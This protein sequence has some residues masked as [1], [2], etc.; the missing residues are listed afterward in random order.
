MC[1]GE[2][3]GFNCGHLEPVG[4]ILFCAKP[5]C[6]PRN[7]FG[8]KGFKNTPCRTC[9]M[10]KYTHDRLV[11]STSVPNP[12]TVLQA[13]HA[14]NHVSRGRPVIHPGREGVDMERSAVLDSV[15]QV[16][17]PEGNV[18]SG[19]PTMKAGETHL[20]PTPPA[21]PPKAV[22]QNI[23]PYTPLQRCGTQTHTA[24]EQSSGPIPQKAQL[25]APKALVSPQRR[26]TEIG[27]ARQQSLRQK[28][29]L[30]GIPCRGKRVRQASPGDLL[31]PGA[32]AHAFTTKPP[33]TDASPPRPAQLQ[34]EEAARLRSDSDLQRHSA[35]RYLEGDRPRPVPN[36]RPIR[37]TSNKHHVPNPGKTI[38]DGDNKIAGDGPD[39]ARAAGSNQNTWIA[40][41]QWKSRIA[42]EEAFSR[43]FP[44]DAVR[45]LKTVGPVFYGPSSTSAD[46]MKM[47][48]PGAQIWRPPP[49]ND[50][51]FWYDD[52]DADSRDWCSDDSDIR[53]W[54]WDDSYSRYGSED[55][56]DAR[57]GAP[58]K[59]DG[60][61]ETWRL[62]IREE[63]P[64]GK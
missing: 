38:E 19:S 36:G 45:P 30:V 1:L 3:V 48:K 9:R 23:R 44:P 29:A 21:T 14:G 61:I 57:S 55:P 52:D 34:V 59:W 35:H 42:E 27:T 17:E 18:H 8:K 15:R 47:C 54:R 28:P 11:G 24:R 13:P 39:V 49:C 56:K 31:T 50:K 53:D 64:W 51:E 22:R 41:Y 4:K 20:P 5:P 43:A 26:E 37:S 63:K 2:I 46:K 60:T 33:H 25:T 16:R 40:S 12:E 58:E 10:R 6:K 7:Y 32:E 62:A